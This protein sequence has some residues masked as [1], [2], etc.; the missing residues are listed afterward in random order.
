MRRRITF[1]LAALTIGSALCA[2]GTTP[3]AIAELQYQTVR[4]LKDAMD[5]A[6]ARG[7]D[8]V[9]NSDSLGCPNT[10]SL[11]PIATEMNPLLEVPPAPRRAPPRLSRQFSLTLAEHELIAP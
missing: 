3:I 6:R 9:E 5:V 4:A 11:P 8:R 7:A 10:A 1:V 2:Q